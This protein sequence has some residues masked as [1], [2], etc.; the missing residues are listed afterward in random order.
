MYTQDEW[1]FSNRIRTNLFPFVWIG[2]LWIFTVTQALGQQQYRAQSAAS[3][4]SAPAAVHEITITGTV[5]QLQNSRSGVHLLVDST[6]GPVDAQLG[7]SVSA[8]VQTSVA[9]GE[10]V[11]ITGSFQTLAGQQ[12][13]L[14]R[15]LTAA[16]HTFTIR[17]NNGFPVHTRNTKQSQI[18]GGAQ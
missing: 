15:Q 10:L 9:A 14:V 17:N 6:Q 7:P 2:L 8:A 13:L 11:Q 3:A 1:T 16:G 18:A 4:A 5:E 12:Y